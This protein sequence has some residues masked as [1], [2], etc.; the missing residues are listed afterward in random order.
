MHRLFVL[1]LPLL[2]TACQNF[3]TTSTA[4]P[5][6][7]VPEGSQLTLLRPLV[8][9]PYELKVYIQGELIAQ[10]ARRLYPYCVLELRDQQFTPQTVQPDTFTIIDVG[11]DIDYFAGLDQPDR[12]YA[13]RI[14]TD[15]HGEGPGLVTYATRLDLRSAQ[16]PQVLSL[17]CAVL[18]DYDLTSQHLSIDQIR[19]ALGPYFRLDIKDA[20]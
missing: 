13:A 2:L 1:L 20:P 3:Y 18:Q 10:G 8:I 5:F 14:I 9:P 19:A 11:R 7:R 15:A 16:Q 4:S 6:Y 12:L 17:T